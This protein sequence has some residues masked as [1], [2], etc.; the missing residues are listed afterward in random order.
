MAAPKVTI[1]NNTTT[2]KLHLSWNKIAGAEK[3][4]VWRATSKNGT[5]KK[6]LTTKNLTYTNTSAVA[7][8]TYYY[9]VRAV[10]GSSYGEFSSVVY[11]TCDCARPTVKITLS[12]N[13]P[14][15]TWA[16][17][18]GADKYVIYRA[19]SKNGTYKKMLTTTKLSYTNTSAGRYTPYYYKI[20]AVSS[21]SSCSVSS[22]SSIVGIV[23]G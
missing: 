9:K 12:S 14:K 7:G 6:M 17:V 23:T 22:Y 19:T 5:Y 13:H 4:E 11:R 1:S 16:K 2:G 20:T 21:R 15:L 8:Y 3:Y 10:C 18:N